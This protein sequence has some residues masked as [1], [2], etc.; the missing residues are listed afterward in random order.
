[1]ETWSW[2]ALG[3]VAL[4]ALVATLVDGLGRLGPRRRRGGGSGDRPGD[5]GTDRDGTD[6]TD[7]DGRR[8]E[9]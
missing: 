3:G 6:P 9:P 2:A 7:G 4:L 5:S 8:P 1:M